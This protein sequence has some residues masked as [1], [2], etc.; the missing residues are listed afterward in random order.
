MFLQ[1]DD[2]GSTMYGYQMDQITEGNDDIIDIA[3]AAAEEEVR[4][5]LEPNNKIEWQDGRLRY[6][7]D[8]VLS[9]VGAARN[10]LILKH[11]ITVAKWWIVDLSSADIIYEQAKERYDR[12][13]DWLKQLA[14]GEVNLSTL[15]TLSPE[16]LEN[17]RPPFSF[18]SRKK[19]NHE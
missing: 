17:D 7:A 10:A 2:L 15:P 13:T 12:S 3:M 5:Y 11:A 19:F 6:D 4:S 9:A 18:G 16:D 1:K 14:S 8:A